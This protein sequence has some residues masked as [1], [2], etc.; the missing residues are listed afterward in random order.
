MLPNTWLFT[1][2]SNFLK[3]K[4]AFNINSLW[5]SKIIKD[6]K[7]Q[8]IHSLSFEMGAHLTRNALS[9]VPKK[10]QTTVDHI[11]LGN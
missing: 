6:W 9:N 1:P 5:L 3:K 8:I 11:I 2:L 10:Q 7:P 4:R